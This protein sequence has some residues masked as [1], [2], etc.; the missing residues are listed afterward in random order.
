MSNSTE[1]SFFNE[2]ANKYNF[3]F[4]TAFYSQWS[5]SLINCN[6]NV[7]YLN[8]MTRG[9]EIVEPA[10]TSS[11]LNKGTV[12]TLEEVSMRFKLKESTWVK[13]VPNS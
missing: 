12:C 3:P 4:F 6:L 5:K 10:S 13:D 2:K 7:F 11:K 1:I 8:C 9:C